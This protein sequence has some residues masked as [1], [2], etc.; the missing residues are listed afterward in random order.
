VL[1]DP[2]ERLQNIRV[3]EVQVRNQPLILV[4]QQVSNDGFAGSHFRS[5]QGGDD[6]LYLDDKDG[7]SRRRPGT[8]MAPALWV[9]AARVVQRG[10]GFHP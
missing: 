3:G 4:H 5:W 2:V 10:F 9:G 6:R 1:V 7:R 8:K